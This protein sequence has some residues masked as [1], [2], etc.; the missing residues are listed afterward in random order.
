[1]SIFKIIF[2]SLFISIGLFLIIIYLNLFYLGYT[3]LDFVYFIIKRGIILFIIIGIIL[4]YK[5]MEMK[6]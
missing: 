5:E 6:K 4:I 3:F 2:G 1:M